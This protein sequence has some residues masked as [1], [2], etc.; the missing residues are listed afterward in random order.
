MSDLVNHP[1]H[2][3]AGN[4]ECL[5]AIESMLGPEGY[6]AFLRG[7]VAKYVWRCPHKGSKLQDCK[8]AAFYLDRLVRLLEGGGG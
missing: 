7:Q 8:K 3:T 2:Y 6:E 4:I 5:D 1:P